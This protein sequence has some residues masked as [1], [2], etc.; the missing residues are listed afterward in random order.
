MVAPRKSIERTSPKSIRAGKKRGLGPG[1]NCTG[2]RTIGASWNPYSSRNETPMAVMSAVS[3][4]W[5]RS[6]R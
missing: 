3:R 4:A 1:G 6:G 5:L 2:L